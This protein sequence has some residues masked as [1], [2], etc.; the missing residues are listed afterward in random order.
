MPSLFDRGAVAQFLVA[1]ALVFAVHGTAFAQ[2]PGPDRGL[3]VTLGTHGGPVPSAQRSQP[4]NLLLEGDRAI[5]VDA[6]DGAAGQLAKVG[7]PLPR[8]SAV[9]ISH[10]HFDHTG[11][12]PAIIGLRFQT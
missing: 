7:V 2:D 4:A 5:L 8:L 9:F 11:G 3:W 1:V 6:G 10:L 12:L